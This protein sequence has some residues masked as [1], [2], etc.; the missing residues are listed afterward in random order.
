MRVWLLA[1]AGAVLARAV[2]PIPAGALIQYP[3]HYFNL[4]HKRLRFLPKGDGYAATASASR[5]LY[6]RGEAYTPPAGVRGRNGSATMQLPFAFPFAGKKW[7]QLWVNYSGSLSFGAAE[8]DV[9]NGFG[10]WPEGT[11][12]WMGATL[13]AQSLAGR[14]RM[15]APLWNFYSLGESTAWIRSSAKEFVVTWDAQRY[16]EYNEGYAPL[17][18]NLFQVRLTPDGAIE[19]RYEE[20]AERDG[21]VGV[22]S[23]QAAKSRVLDENGASMIEDTG[24][25]LRITT[26][27][28]TDRKAATYA[29]VFSRGDE[30][31][32]A[33]LRMP[34]EERNTNCAGY[35]VVRGSDLEFYISKLDLGEG[36]KFEWAA[37]GVSEGEALA[38]RSV[39]AG[40]GGNGAVPLAT[41][42]GVTGGNLFEVFHYPSVS[43]AH[44]VTM[45]HIYRT[46]APVDDFAV[47][48]TDFRIDDLYNHGGST[49][50]LNVRIEGI[51][52]E[53]VEDGGAKAEY[54]SGALQAAAGPIY[55][56][57]RF[58]ETPKDETRSYRNYAFATAWMAHELT[59]RWSAALRSTVTANPDVLHDGDPCHCHWNDWLQ[60]PA[61]ATVSQLF[62]D[63]AYPEGSMMGGY[64]Y[65]EQEGGV[66]MRRHAPNA[67]PMGVSALDLYVMGLMGADEVP[68]TFL[69]AGAKRAGEDLYTGTKLPVRMAD[70]VKASG[71]RRPGVAESPKEFKLGMYLLYDGAQARPEKLA[72]A[73]GI[74]K[75]LMEYFEV[76]TEGRMRLVVQRRERAVATKR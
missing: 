30:P 53:E 37:G 26:P 4:N 6:A 14:V 29:G 8:T 43:K 24:T 52:H 36:G 31:C 57:P 16:M 73:R 51:G 19:F 66:V 28:R 63:D 34:G 21:I 39:S 68:V 2:T 46:A 5:Q 32:K 65:D 22:F 12:R 76:A 9:F 42:R 13:D 10:T 45:Q 38:T 20:V 47:V 69:L 7:T 35:G 48:V 17:G 1:M 56:G 27:L 49:G 71:A 54:G 18:R 50:P 33:L 41:A 62:T 55:L 70:I 3:A 40:L 64:L 44:A 59:H 60:A 72:Q 67:A 25:A 58:Q 61:V 74:E 11:M 15:I 23:G 75:A